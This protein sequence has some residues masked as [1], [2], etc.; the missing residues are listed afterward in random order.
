MKAD[1]A[2]DL[3]VEDLSAGLAAQAARPNRW[4][5]NIL[6]SL[7]TLV[8]LALGIV[9]AAFLFVRQALS[10]VLVQNNST[11]A[12][13]LTIDGVNVNDGVN[14]GVNASESS[15]E[16]S[17][18][19][20]QGDA[21]FRG[22]EFEVKPGW[23]ASRVANA[24]EADGFI[25]NAR[26]F[27]L[28]LR[29]KGYDRSIGEGLYYIS[30]KMTSM[31]I[32]EVLQAG[33][34][35]RTKR[36]VIPEGFRTV[37]I[38][39]RLNQAGFGREKDFIFYIRNPELFKENYGVDY[40]PDDAT[41]EGYLFPASY[42]VPHEA[43]SEDVLAL[44]LRRFEEEMDL[45]TLEKVNDLGLTKKQWVILASIVQ[46]EAGSVEEM[47]IISGVFLNRLELGM[48]LQSDPTVAYGLGKDL[49]ELD[50]SA[51]D[52]T[53]AADHA[54]NT[55]TRPGFPVGPIS[56]PGNAALQAVLRPVRTNADGQ[57]Y[58]F[59][60]HGRDGNFY[61]NISLDDHNRDVAKYL[62]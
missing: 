2:K 52:F 41:L 36:V 45:A 29:Y 61:P 60:L 8:L 1:K 49:T 43:T 28:W 33:G 47:P 38:A 56:N 24:L 34:Q 50:R 26:I 21:G 15:S 31:E 42:E 13:T 23:G 3:T 16:T 22:V 32:A 19:E 58:M 11:T 10:P 9:G 62:R 55:Y 46:S 40:L 39:K 6:L 51:G 12:Q 18:E 14:D 57:D 30:P 17:G 44:M 37:D 35:P 53:E 4:L 48:A 5:R 27:S 59:F 54:W 7:L 25:K 20:L